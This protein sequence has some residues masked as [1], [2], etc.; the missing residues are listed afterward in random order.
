MAL[1][2]TLRPPLDMDLHGPPRARRVGDLFA[3]ARGAGRALPVV[4][5]SDEPF[6]PHVF[7]AAAAE[8]VVEEGAHGTTWWMHMPGAGRDN[9]LVVWDPQRRK[10]SVGAWSRRTPRSESGAAQERSHGR[11]LWHSST[12]QPEADGAHATASIARGW[13][14]VHLPRAKP[15]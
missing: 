5:R 8:R 12:W 11:L 3:A 10:L 1:T 2:D 15:A 14:G 7:Q 9:T 6:E 4:V 13:V